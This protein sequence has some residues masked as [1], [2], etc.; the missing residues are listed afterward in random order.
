[1]VIWQRGPLVGWLRWAAHITAR[2]CYHPRPDVASS[3]RL[4]ATRQ[5][6]KTSH[7][8][9]AYASML[10]TFWTKSYTVAQYK[11]RWVLI[12]GKRTWQL[13]K[14]MWLHSEILSGSPVI[15]Q[16][17]LFYGK[18]N[19]SI[20]SDTPH[21]PSQRTAWERAPWK[22]M[23]FIHMY[24]WWCTSTIHSISLE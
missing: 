7:S 18:K 14:C 2:R 24:M 16:K 17:Q 23:F 21:W 5:P 3:A 1:M 8:L 22:S 9:S 12:I 19:M 20:F 13:L 4:N 15:C 11:Q 10:H 6:Q